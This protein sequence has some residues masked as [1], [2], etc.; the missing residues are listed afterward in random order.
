MR[1]WRHRPDEVPPPAEEPISPEALAWRIGAADSRPSSAPAA[2]SVRADVGRAATSRVRARVRPVVSSAT[3][4]LVLWRDASAILFGILALILVVQLALSG[5]GREPSSEV[6]GL[7]FRPSGDVALG[8]TTS[9]DRI[10]LPTIGPVL[11]PGLIPGIEA[12]RTPLPAQTQALAV[13]RPVRRPVPLPTP[14][15]TLPGPTFVPMP[16]LTPAPTPASTPGPTPTPEPP[17]PPPPPT[18]APTLAPTPAPTPTP[19]PAVARISCDAPIGKAVTCRSNSSDVVPASEVWSADQ[20]GTMTPGGDTPPTV[21]FE[22]AAD[23]VGDVSIS[24]TVTGADG[25][26]STDTVVVSIL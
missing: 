19:T 26:Q 2:G 12:T 3:R 7:T 10:E 14:R 8:A 13:S 5:D 23:F 21:T 20:P 22:F 17:P 6:A 4:R 9:P 16:L 1:L 15:P 18:P 24:L 11:D 25:G